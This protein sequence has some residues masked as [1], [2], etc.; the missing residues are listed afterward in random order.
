MGLKG[1]LVSSITEYIFLFVN[2]IRVW[3]AVAQCEREIGESR[4][5]HRLWGR[6]RE[7]VRVSQFVSH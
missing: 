7:G 6:A 4:H 3:D 5:H 1:S 2:P